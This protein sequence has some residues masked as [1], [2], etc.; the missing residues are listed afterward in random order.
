M[1]IFTNLHFI[2]KIYLHLYRC[3]FTNMNDRLL[4]F[5]EV[6]KLSPS[7]FADALG[8][9]RPRLSHIFS[10]R[11]K[12][13]YDFI[14]KFMSR[15]PYVNIEWLVLGKG[16]M[17]KDSAPRLEEGQY[18]SDNKDIINLSEGQQPHENAI[19][20]EDPASVRE[21]PAPEKIK[22]ISRITVFYTDGSFEEFYR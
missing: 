1:Y 14:E 3:K 6:E 18:N 20:A 17:F 8:I 10:G 13:G 9:Q 22:T 12:P 4:Q 21:N 7:Q 2:K 16:K 11:N 5:L 19:F 15:Y